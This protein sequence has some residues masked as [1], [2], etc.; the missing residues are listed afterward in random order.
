VCPVKINLPELLLDLREKGDEAGWGEAL[1][2][3]AWSRIASRPRL[4][5]VLG[6]I[7][8]RTLRLTESSGIVGRCIGKLM[9]ALVPPLRT[10]QAGRVLPPMPTRSFRQL[11][12]AGLN[13]EDPSA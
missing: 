6:M 13:D 9:S 1:G 5:S 7:L 8:T 10:W 4:N 2:L 12:R 3:G 11:W